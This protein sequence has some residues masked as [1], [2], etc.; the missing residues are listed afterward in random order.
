MKYPKVT[1]KLDLNLSDV[2]SGK[3]KQ[4]KD[5][6]GKYVVNQIKEF[7]SEGKSPVSGER[8]FKSLNKK[9]ASEMKGGNTLANLRLDGDLMRALEYK[10]T[11]DGIEIGV[12]KASETG[13]ADGHNRHHKVNPVLPKRRYI[14]AEDQKFKANINKGIKDIAS[15]Y[16]DDEEDQINRQIEERRAREA[17]ERAARR[18]AASQEANIFAQDILDQL[19]LSARR[20]TDE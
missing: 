6:V 3:R 13:K 14:P 15:K 16:Q 2:P 8:S 20:E 11:K 5:E 7:T 4:F 1:K 10:R 12:F 19:I 9:Y 17:Q 18:E